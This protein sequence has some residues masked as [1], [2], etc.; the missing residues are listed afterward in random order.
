MNNDEYRMQKFDVVDFL[1]CV[2]SVTPDINI[3]T[4]HCIG[5]YLKISEFEKENIIN[6]ISYL[7]NSKD[8]NKKKDAVDLLKDICS[9]SNRGKIYELLTYSY[10]R[11]LCIPFTTHVK[12]DKAHCFKAS[13]DYIG[14]GKITF[15]FSNHIEDEESAIFFE[16]KSFG[17]SEPLIIKLKQKIQEKMPEYY[18]ITEGSLDSSTIELQKTALEKL[19]DI[20]EAL[21]NSHLF[22]GVLLYT[23][24]ELNISIR[25]I[26]FTLLN[27]S[28]TYVGGI[29]VF[30][31]Y[32]WA[33]ENETYFIRHCSQLCKDNPFIIIC[34]FDEHFAPTFATNLSDHNIISFRSLSR[35]IFMNLLNNKENLCA[36]DPKAQKNITVSDAI[37]KI[38]AIWFVDINKSHE[39]NNNSSWA[40]INPNAD[41]PI[42][43]YQIDQLFHNNGVYFDDFIH[44]NY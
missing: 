25:A 35:R 30:N 43:R 19:S 38:S 28:G 20:C 5:N 3:N 18:I 29:S 33:K 37:R 15:G 41:N 24:K 7:F 27:Q 9:N 22:N 4:K 14:D 39:Y 23:L 12:I 8:T 2:K 34:P 36:Y 26:P 13:N 44:D 1:N 21:K 10:L 11:E 42:P 17:I 31:G 40:F 6:T 32:K 16:I